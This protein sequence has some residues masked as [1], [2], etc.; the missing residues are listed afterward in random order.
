MNKFSIIT[1]LILP[2]LFFSCGSKEDNKKD[3]ETDKIELSGKDIYQN[4]CSACHQENGEGVEGSF[5]GLKGKECNIEIIING[6]KGLVMPSFKNQFSDKE[7]SKL[8][9]Y[10][11]KSFGN[12]FNEVK[13][14]DI[15]KIRKWI[16]NWKTTKF[17]N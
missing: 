9:T 12:N 11:N 16:Y 10:V 4:H 1:L 8:A 14:E 17:S 7:I 15:A 3:K 2:I 5:P 6:S 13:A